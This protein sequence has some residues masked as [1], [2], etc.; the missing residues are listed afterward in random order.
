[1][2]AAQKKTCQIFVPKKTLESKIS[3]ASLEIQST[4]LPGLV[5]WPPSAQPEKLKQQKKYITW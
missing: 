2:Q 1:M 5:A 4:P 3:K